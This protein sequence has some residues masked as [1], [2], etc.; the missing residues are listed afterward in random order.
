MMTLIIPPAN[1][2]LAFAARVIDE[3]FDAARLWPFPAH[4][5][6]MSPADV[7]VCRPK[8]NRI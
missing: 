3:L 8:R 4:D 5:P 2:A 1:P 7:A 6:T